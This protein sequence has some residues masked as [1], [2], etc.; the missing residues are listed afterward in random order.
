[1]DHDRRALGYII[2]GVCNSLYLLGGEMEL[3]VDT[4]GN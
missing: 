4:I 3:G 1:M 2:E